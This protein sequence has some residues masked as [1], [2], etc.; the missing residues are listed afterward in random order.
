MYFE[1]D[2]AYNRKKSHMNGNTGL[3]PQ[4][5]KLLEVTTNGQGE[6]SQAAGAPLFEVILKEL[7]EGMLGQEE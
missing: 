7:R 1:E 2:H 3:K 6:T 5:F 4:S